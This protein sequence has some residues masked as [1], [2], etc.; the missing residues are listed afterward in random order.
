MT[1]EWVRRRDPVFDRYLR[2]LLFQSGAIVEADHADDG[3]A[4]ERPSHRHDGADGTLGL[5][6][7][8]ARDARAAPGGPAREE[9]R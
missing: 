7:L 1:L 8:R 6:S 5:G 4:H 2:R 3:S 9:R